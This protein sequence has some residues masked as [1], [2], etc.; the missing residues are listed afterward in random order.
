MSRRDLLAWTTTA[1]L[2]GQQI[3]EKMFG[4]AQAY[5]RFMG[6]WSRQMAPLL[7]DFAGVAN[8]G[9]VLDIGSGSG[10]MAFELA[11]R[12]PGVH[13]TGIDPSAEYVGYAAT[14]N[15][16]PSR[17]GFQT[18]DARHMEFNDST[19]TASV[20]LLVFNFIPDP[21]KAAREARRVTKAKGPVAAAVWDYGGRMPMLRAFWDAAT[22]IDPAAEKL[23][24]K[25]MP[26]CRSGELSQLWKQEGLKQVEEQ[27]LETQIEFKS[28]SDYWEPF[29]LGQGPAGAYVRKLDQSRLEALRI[30]VKQRLGQSSENKMF[31]LP[32]RVWAVRGRVPA[33]R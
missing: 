13:V 31:A 21:G 7:I 25:N 6:R 3:D 28:F 33:M 15:S 32:A 10:S 23:D 19:F 4:N 1:A 24:E 18:G 8:T 26:L 2:N 9:R 14:K 12:R 20:S 22:E 17:V 5:E 29:L 30:A 27:P 11:K 16:F